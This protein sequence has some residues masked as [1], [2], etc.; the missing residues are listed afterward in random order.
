M[1][2]LPRPL[3]V[4]TGALLILLSPV[5]GIVPGPGG[6]FVFAAGLVL[7]LRG[8]ARA[9]RGWVVLKRRWPRL[10]AVADRT[11]RRRSALR[12]HARARAAGLD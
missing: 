8:S 3:L 11:M 1:G 4:G 7:V 9:R 2:S 5:V 10:G 6:I 12:R